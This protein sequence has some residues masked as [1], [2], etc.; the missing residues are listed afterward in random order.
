MLDR[1][2]VH[3]YSV[4]LFFF[5]II[6]CRQ[7]PDLTK[8]KKNLWPKTIS[9]T[10]VSCINALNHDSLSSSLKSI[11]EIIKILTVH[12]DEEDVED[13]LN[14]IVIIYES[15][16]NNITSELKKTVNTEKRINILLDEFYKDNSY[17]DES[18]NIKEFKNYTE[19]N[20]LY[21]SAYDA[22]DEYYS[23]YNV[24][25]EAWEN[26]VNFD[27]QE[28]TELENII[29]ELRILPSEMLDDKIIDEIIDD[30]DF[31]KLIGKIKIVINNKIVELTNITNDELIERRMERIEKWGK[32]E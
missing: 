5:I 24:Y 31:E 4:I 10:E 21:I 16:T 1:G 3:K 9:E 19:Y 8:D 7:T 18:G 32:N 29:E 28:Y 25:A 6:C 14:T 2:G 22:R 20:E 26:L 17:I 30:N 11:E 15:I 27:S 13:L 23:A 12:K